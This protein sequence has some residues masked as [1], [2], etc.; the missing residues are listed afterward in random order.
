MNSRDPETAWRPGRFDARRGPSQLLFGRMYEDPAIEARAFRPGGRI[1]CIASAG[2]TARDLSRHHDVVA[3]DVNPMQIAYAERRASGAPPLRGKAERM[4]DR[5]R[6]LAPLAGWRRARVEEFLDLDDPGAQLEFWRS[7]LDRTRFRA[8]TDAIFSPCSLRAFYA[9]AFLRGLPRHFGGILRARLERGFARHP[10]RGNPFLRALFLGELP[11][12]PPPAGAGR[13]RFVHADAA[14]F[15]EGQPRSS[16]DGFA[17]S[18]VLDGARDDYRARL[19]AAISRA[20][21]PGAV[22]VRRSFS[23]PPGPSPANLAA[24]D[25]AML[26]GIVDVS[27]AASP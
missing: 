9:G 4:L 26:W 7:H 17:I 8:A 21:A 12:G 10:N 16:F 20:A 27:P 3:V 2:C 22:V 19:F 18:N 14:A 23:E 15:L 5:I 25:R 13:I 1:F 11:A 24:D 6:R